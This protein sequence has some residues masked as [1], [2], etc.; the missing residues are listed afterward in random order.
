MNFRRSRRESYCHVVE[1]ALHSERGGDG[2]PI[3]EEHAVARVVDASNL[4]A[5]Q[6]GDRTL[7]IVF[8]DGRR[9]TSRSS[10]RWILAGS[11]EDTRPAR[12]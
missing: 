8:T 11:S 5:D 4:R 2:R 10:D 12:V 9:L 6:Q 1:R 3:R 7:S